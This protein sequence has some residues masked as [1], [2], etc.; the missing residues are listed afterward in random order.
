MNRP[1]RMTSSSDGFG[2][3]INLFN[4]ALWESLWISDDCVHISFYGIRYEFAS[5][6]IM[7]QFE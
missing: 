3:I 7:R 4:G 1:L 6:F 2:Y 5:S